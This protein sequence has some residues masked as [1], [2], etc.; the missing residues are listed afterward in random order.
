MW[1]I[2]FPGTYVRYL[3]VPQNFDPALGGRFWSGELRTLRADL[4]RIAGRSMDDADLHRSIGL[5]N[6]NRQLLREVDALRRTSPNGRRRSDPV[7]TGSPKRRWL[8]AWQS[9]TR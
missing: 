6:R 7:A 9:G 4:D 3:D 1:Q 8:A 2:L 5:Y